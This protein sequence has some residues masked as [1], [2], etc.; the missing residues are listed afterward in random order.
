M[1]TLER[2]INRRGFFYARLFTMVGILALLAGCTT[3]PVFLQHPQT[4][5]KVQCGPYPESTRE[6]RVVADERMR[7]CI[8]DLQRQGYVLME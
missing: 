5:T 4:G 3:D 8:A 1:G 6:A 7:S 2:V